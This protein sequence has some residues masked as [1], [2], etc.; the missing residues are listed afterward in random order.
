MTTESE[1][2]GLPEHEEEVHRLGFAR[3]IAVL[4]SPRTFPHLLLLV[5]TSS[6]LY[7]LVKSS[8]DSG[9]MAAMAYIAFAMAYTI[10]ALA[11]RSERWKDLILTT[12]FKDTESKG[13]S[14]WAITTTDQ[15][16]DSS[17]DPECID[18]GDSILDI[19]G[20]API[21]GMGRGCAVG[22]GCPVHSLVDGASDIIPHD[23]QGRHVRQTAVHG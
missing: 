8:E 4:L 10:I 5:V 12:P 18:D 1:Q 17:A 11:A 15:G 3:L 9:V 7:S 21:G 20:R 2:Q 6:I 23:H 16:M 14:A 19:L 13:F 22:T